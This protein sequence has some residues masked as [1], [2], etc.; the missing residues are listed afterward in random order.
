M[1]GCALDTDGDGNCP[2][3]PLGCFA[4]AVAAEVGRLV[5]QH[6]DVDVPLCATCF[7]HAVYTVEAIRRRG[8]RAILQAGSATWRY[9]ARELDDG[10]ASTHFGYEWIPGDPGHRERIEAGLMPEMHVWAATVDPPA[11]VDYTTGLWPEQARR[12]G[13]H[14]WNAAKP[15]PFVW[16]VPTDACYIPDRDAVRCALEMAARVFGVKRAREL[17]S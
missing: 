6:V 17:V 12:L 11:I 3:H 10:V 1:K 16:G 15:P 5:L 7:Y 8:V 2:A 13:G 4:T 14:V 9:R